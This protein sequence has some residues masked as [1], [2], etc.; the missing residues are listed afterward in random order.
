MKIRIWLLIIILFFLCL[1][2]SL[3]QDRPEDRFDLA[4]PAWDIGDYLCALDEF[5]SILKSPDGRRFF[6][7]IALITGEL[8]P[9][10]EITRNG[11]TIRISPDDRSCGK[12]K[13]FGR[14]K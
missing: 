6:E 5:E 10:R 1:G 11:R 13:G 3:P 2:I 4:R 8:Y 9:A 7:P 14:K 12:M